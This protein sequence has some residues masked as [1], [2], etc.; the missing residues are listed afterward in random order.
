M[1]AYVGTS[2]EVKIEDDTSDITER[3]HDDK[4]RPYLCMVCDKRFMTK[5]SLIRHKQTHTYDKLYSCTQCEQR[6]TTQRYLSS[7]MNVHSSKFMCT[8]CG[9]C[10]TNSSVLTVHRRS[11]SGEK[12]FECAVCS[13]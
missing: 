6:F 8:E 13:K 7:H 9:K 3:L 2:F 4:P 1:Y 5:Q 12:L 11:H 10:F